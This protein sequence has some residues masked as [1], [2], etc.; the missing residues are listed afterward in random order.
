MKYFPWP[1][2]WQCHFPFDIAGFPV[3]WENDTFPN[4][5]WSYKP[6][7]FLSI[8]LASI[9]FIDF[10]VGALQMSLKCHPKAK[11]VKELLSIWSPTAI[12]LLFLLAVLQCRDSFKMSVGGKNFLW[13]I[14]TFYKIQRNA[15][16][17]Q[18]YH[19]H[20]VESQFCRSVL[21]SVYLRHWCGEG[22]GNLGAL[23]IEKFSKPWP[24]LWLR[25]Y[26]PSLLW[27]TKN[28]DSL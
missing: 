12:C 10:T 25:M 19:S 11:N 2:V 6:C 7:S 18:N 8:K 5:P 17:L 14:P 21:V 15:S 3:L 4:F 27:V 24:L 9:F 26:L 16:M 20:I 1:T 28:F 13:N 23:P 22:W